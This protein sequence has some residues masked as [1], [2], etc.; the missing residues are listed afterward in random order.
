[1]KEPEFMSSEIIGLQMHEYRKLIANIEI[2]RF[3]FLIVMQLCCKNDFSRFGG[4][5]EISATYHRCGAGKIFAKKPRL[6]RFRDFSAFAASTFP[7]E[8]YESNLSQLP[9]RARRDP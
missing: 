8:I 7:G 1:M 2:A 9:L 5:K 4:F 6:T 3:P